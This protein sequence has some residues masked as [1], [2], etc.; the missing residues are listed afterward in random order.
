[1]NTAN[2][3][4]FLALQMYRAVDL[5]SRSRPHAL[6]VKVSSLSCYKYAGAQMF[7][8]YVM[9]VGLNLRIQHR[10]Y[11]IGCMPMFA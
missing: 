5:S 3:L 1:M 9:S 2:S 6:A 8:N 4:Q 11:K 10:K 7:K